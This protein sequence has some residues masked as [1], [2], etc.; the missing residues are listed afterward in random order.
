MAKKD[1]IEKK[2]KKFENNGDILDTEPGKI[3]YFGDKYDFILDEKLKSDNIDTENKSIT[4]KMDLS[5][6]SNL[7]SWYKKKAKEYLT[8]RTEELIAE[9]SFKV[10]KIT[11]RSQKTRWGS[12]SAKNDISLNSALLKCPS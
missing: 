11:V 12:C 1:W 2:L 3:I 8:R 5:K 7:N 9:H 6:E 4:S 10:G